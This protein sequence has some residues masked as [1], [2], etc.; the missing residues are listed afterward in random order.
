MEKLPKLAG[1]IIRYILLLI[2]S[3][4]NLYLIYKIFAPLT[5]YP[6][7]FIIKQ[8]YSNAILSQAS[9]IL[10]G[11]TIIIENACIAGSAYYLL[12]ILNLTTHMKLKTHIHSL[13]FSL[14]VFLLFNILRISFF[15]FLFASSFSL[16]NFV[17]LLFWYF[18]STLLVFLIWL[19]NIKLF[20]ITGIPVYDD[21]NFLY[22]KIKK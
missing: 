12:L 22:S 21:L 19:A 7:F 13:L 5:I 17:H 15:S 2:L 3:L 20:R 10:N 1:I 9:I 14:S 6:S 8:A 16:F 4:G 18:L 11:Y